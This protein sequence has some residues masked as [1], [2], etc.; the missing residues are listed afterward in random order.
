VSRLCWLLKEARVGRGIR[1]RPQVLANLQ[2]WLSFLWIA[3]QGISLNLISFRTL[4]HMFRSDAA[5]HGIEGFCGLSGKVWSLKLA[6]DCRAGCLEGIYL[7]LI[8]FLVGG[9]ISIWVEILAGCVRP[10]SCLPAQGD[11]SLVTG[12][13]QKSNFLDNNHPLQLEAA[14]HLAFILLDAGVLLNS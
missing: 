2:L 6:P 11:S 5:E 14:R 3:L 1:L 9:I 7:N 4:T 13:L 12:W 10:G 8:K